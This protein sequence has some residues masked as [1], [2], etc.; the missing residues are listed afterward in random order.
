MVRQFP[1]N[2][3]YD[4]IRLLVGGGR[5]LSAVVEASAALR[6]CLERTARYPGRVWGRALR[7]PMMPLK[8]AWSTGFFSR[9][10]QR[11][12]SL[13]LRVACGMGCP[14]PPILP[15]A[16]SALDIHISNHHSQEHT[17]TVKL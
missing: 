3:W 8:S 13:E 5:G 17:C 2:G 11:E 12:D 10:E 16:P 14:N 6:H 1:W 15:F 4:L 7:E 9:L